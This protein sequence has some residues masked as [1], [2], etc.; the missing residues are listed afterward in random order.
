MQRASEPYRDGTAGL[1][2][3]H[4]G[5][6]RQTHLRHV[7]KRSGRLL[8][9]LDGTRRWLTLMEHSTADYGH[10]SSPT[11]AGGTLIVHFADLVGLD[12][13]TGKERWRLKARPLHGTSIATK[14]G[15]TDA[16]VT[17]GGMLVRARAMAWS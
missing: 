16:V 4:A 14:V 12:A 13:E 17:P 15:D 8:D 7:R 5:Q 3:M 2:A 9:D 10:G 6:R 1:F 11:L